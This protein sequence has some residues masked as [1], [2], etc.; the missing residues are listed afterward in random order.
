MIL[1]TAALLFQ[2]PP[3]QA[4]AG[5][6]RLVTTFSYTPFEDTGSPLVLVKLIDK[7]HTGTFLLDTG[8]GPVAITEAMAANL[9]LKPKP[10]IVEGKPF[11]VGGKPV[12]GVHLT[13]LQVGQF[14][15]SA[16]AAVLKDEELSEASGTT[17]EVDG[18]L[19]VNM[20]GTLA[21][22]FDFSKHE[23]TLRYPGNLTDAEVR[24]LGFTEPAVP[25]AQEEKGA[26]FTA[27]AQAANGTSHRQDAFVIDTGAAH[28]RLSYP[29]AQ[30]LKLT[31]L[32]SHASP[33]PT[34]SGPIN[35]NV[36]VLETLRLGR[37]TI[38]NHLIA[39]PDQTGPGQYSPSSLGMDKLSRFRV[40]LDF[41]AK[42]MY[43]QPVASL[44]DPVAPPAVPAPQTPAT[45]P[46]AK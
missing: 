25:L 33:V 4:Q 16:D 43:L 28:S 12:D 39:Y 8:T 22:L 1:V 10:M 34:L 17:G 6:Q 19:G 44:T 38:G 27:L 13:V 31:P 5:L 9:N 29:L 30:Q 18:I 26:V 36:A 40:L 42:K 35:Y 37:F 24:Q 11:L 45:S 32:Q 7:D 23:I 15:V 41:P 21:V 20:L 3:V 2:P 14:P 46:L